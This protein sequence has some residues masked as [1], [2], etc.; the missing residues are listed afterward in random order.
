MPGTGRDE[1]PQG[2]VSG[3]SDPRQEVPAAVTVHELV[4]GTQAFV[5][6]VD[7]FY[8]RVE[9]DPPLR[10]VYPEDLEPGKRNLALFLTQYWGGPQTYSEL[11]GHPRL[12]R[13]HGPFEVTPDGAARWQTHMLAAIRSMGFP[14]P[15]EDAMVEYV[16]RFTSSMINTPEA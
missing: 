2:D 11:R 3:G 12:R 10:A 6:L 13:R 14:E 1:L 8:A 7:R 15:A 9:Q 4:G 5:E 16:E